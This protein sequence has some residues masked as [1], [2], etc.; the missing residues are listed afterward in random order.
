[1]REAR[2][3]R[4]GSPALKTAFAEGLLSLYRAGE[5]AKLP[6]DQQA[7]VTVQWTM[8]TLRQKEGQAIATQVI[9]EALRRSPMDLDEI[10]SAIHDAIALKLH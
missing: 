3:L 9:R 10:A 6:L 5:I 1:M 2:L 7:A 4:Q 8:R